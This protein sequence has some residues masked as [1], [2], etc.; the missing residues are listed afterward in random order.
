V[1][2]CTRHRVALAEA[3]KPEHYQYYDNQ[4]NNINES[5]HDFSYEVVGPARLLRR[6]CVVCTLALS[7][8]IIRVASNYRSFRPQGACDEEVTCENRLCM[9][10]Q[11]GRPALIAA[12]LPRRSLRHVLS[13]CSRR[14]PDPELDQQLIGNSLLTP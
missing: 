10:L 6:C 4:T 9:V 7:S 2:T 8:A 1:S 14:D 3:K 13:R 12:R 5:I 11:E